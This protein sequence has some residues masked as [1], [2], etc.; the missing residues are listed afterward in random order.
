MQRGLKKSKLV[1]V[2]FYNHP[3]ANARTNQKMDESTY[4]ARILNNC[5][6][7]MMHVEAQSVVDEIQLSEDEFNQVVKLSTHVQ[8]CLSLPFNSLAA[9]NAFMSRVTHK[10]DINQSSLR[11]SW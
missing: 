6:H 8:F 10:V 3:H 7:A 9:Q 4:F 11:N 1:F 5:A 2:I